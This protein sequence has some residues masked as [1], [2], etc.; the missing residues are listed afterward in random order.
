[1]IY[2]GLLPSLEFSASILLAHLLPP[3]IVC[4]GLAASLWSGALGLLYPR[5]SLW[6]PQYTTAAHQ[7]RHGRAGQRNVKS[8]EAV[9]R[10]VTLSVDAVRVLRHIGFGSTMRVVRPH[11]QCR[12][13]YR[14]TIAEN[15][16]AR[17]LS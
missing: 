8:D 16:V 7:R 15:G 3:T 17:G 2:A 11:V 13:T 14:S 10:A 12:R 1:M 5:S 9:N 6:W 4:L